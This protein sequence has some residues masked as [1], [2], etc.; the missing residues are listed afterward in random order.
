LIVGAIDRILH[1]HV[2]RHGGSSCWPI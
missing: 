1:G 2:M